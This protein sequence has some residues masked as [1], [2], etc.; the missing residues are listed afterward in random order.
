MSKLEK[1]DGDIPQEVINHVKGGPKFS[2][3]I[4]TDD[5]GHEERTRRW[6]ALKQIWEGFL[7][8]CS[9]ET[10]NYFARNNNRI[11][12][13]VIFSA[14]DGEAEVLIQFNPANK[15]VRLTAK[16]DQEKFEKVL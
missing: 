1:A 14:M 6:K 10:L 3:T 16:Q 7:T 5:E 2:T 11:A 9:P 15:Y 4:K 13:F 12:R 8:A